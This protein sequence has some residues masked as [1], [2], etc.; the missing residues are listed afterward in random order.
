MALALRSAV[1]WLIKF[2]QRH[3]SPWTPPSCRF[4]PT[5]SHYTYEAIEKFGLLRGGWL[6]VK[7]ICR[8]HPFS[9][10]AYDPVPQQWQQQQWQQSVP[11]AADELNSDEL[12][13][14]NNSRDEQMPS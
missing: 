2:Y 6:G 5:C 8:C 9:K 7:R 12:N 14:L 13:K 1:L 3:I 11:K 10:R 4:L